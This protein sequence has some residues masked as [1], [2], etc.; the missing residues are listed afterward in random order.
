MPSPPDERS[1][2]KNPTPT[3]PTTPVLLGTP[4]APLPS[5]GGKAPSPK[6]F[7]PKYIP[8]L[9]AYDSTEYQEENW[10]Q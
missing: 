1:P 7:S 9:I 8:R 2:R 10:R 6:R 4:Q 3:T 5:V